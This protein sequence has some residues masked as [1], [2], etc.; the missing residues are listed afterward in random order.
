MNCK[1]DMRRI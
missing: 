1:Y